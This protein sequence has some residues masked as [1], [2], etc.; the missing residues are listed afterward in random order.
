MK[1]E[2]TPILHGSLLYGLTIFD[3]KREGL[4]LAVFLLFGQAHDHH[5]SYRRCANQELGIL[6][7]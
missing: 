5:S 2:V 7:D 3:S 1:R 6:D 4:E